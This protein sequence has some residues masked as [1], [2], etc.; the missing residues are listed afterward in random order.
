[1]IIDDYIK[2]LIKKEVECKHD[3]SKLLTQIKWLVIINIILSIVF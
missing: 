2:E 3:N 1:M